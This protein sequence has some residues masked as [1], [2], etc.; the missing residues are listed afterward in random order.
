MY[1]AS[2]ESLWGNCTSIFT[3]HR[4]VS[5]QWKQ[6]MTCLVCRDLFP[7]DNSFVFCFWFCSFVSVLRESCLFCLMLQLAMS[8]NIFLF[9]IECCRHCMDIFIF[10]SHCY[11]FQI[12]FFFSSFRN[13]GKV[14]L[15]GIFTFYISNCVVTLRR[16][17]MHIIV[18]SIKTQNATL[19]TSEKNIRLINYN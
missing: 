9:V 10:H 7:Y 11:I 14:C 12:L 8:F 17:N 13:W 15:T 5:V 16:I 19:A 6:W 4:T 18:S 2:A 1:Y 3:Y